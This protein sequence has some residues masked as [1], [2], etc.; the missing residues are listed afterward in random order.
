MTSNTGHFYDEIIKDKIKVLLNYP[1]LNDDIKFGHFDTQH[2][3]E[4]SIHNARQL[5]TPPH[6]E[7]EGF[8]LLTSNINLHIFSIDE[9]TPNI[10]QPFNTILVDTL[11][12]KRALLLGAV[13]RHE[14][15][16]D[17]GLPSH[18]EIRSPAGFIHADWGMQRLQALTTNPDPILVNNPQINH[19][20]IANVINKASR[21]GMYNIWIPLVHLTNNNLA[22]CSINGMNNE[23][24][25]RS[26]MFNG[27]SE[28]M[29]LKYNQHHQWFYYPL[30]QSNELL[31]FKQYDSIEND[32]TY[33]CVFH[34]AFNIVK[35]DNLIMNPR[36]SLELRFLV[37]Y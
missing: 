23:D 16:H 9:L 5:N 32:D 34:T 35:D 26:F 31:I 21:W 30:M 3:K 37:N 25:V 29:T 1:N 17:T 10:I 4:T 24:I 28:I 11:S 6:I 13:I 2:H 12:A 19:T 18:S 33:T 20:D 27:T 22:L 36:K 15:K 8:C 7:Q 14:Q